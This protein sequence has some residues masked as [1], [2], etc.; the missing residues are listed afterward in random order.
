MV[1]ATL[2]QVPTARE[3]HRKQHA[4]HEMPGDAGGG[5]LRAAARARRYEMG[6]DRVD[7]PSGDDEG[8][9]RRRGRE[10]AGRCIGAPG[11]RDRRRRQHR[12]DG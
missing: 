12:K 6:R 1:A 3:S 5:R 11:D 2:D 9:K 7:R 8:G 4:Q 10:R